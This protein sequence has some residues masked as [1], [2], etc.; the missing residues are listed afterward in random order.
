MKPDAECDQFGVDRAAKAMSGI[1]KP[2]NLVRFG[3]VG[4][5]D[6]AQVVVPPRLGA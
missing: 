4:V 3:T 2:E 1:G 5:W 6:G